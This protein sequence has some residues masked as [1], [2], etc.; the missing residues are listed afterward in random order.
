MARAMKLRPIF[1]WDP[2]HLFRQPPGQASVVERRRHSRVQLHLPVRLRW[3]TPPGPLDGGHGDARGLPRR[4]PGSP[5]RALPGACH[6]L[7]D[8]SL[9]LHPSAGAARDAS[10]ARVEDQ[11]S[12]GS[13]VAID[14]E[15]P[16]RPAARG[17]ASGAERRRQERV[18]VALPIRVRPADSLWPEET[19]TMDITEDG[20]RFWTTRLYSVG[21]DLRIFSPRGSLPSRWIT[22]A[23]LPARI[24]R[25]TSRPG[26]IA[27]E[28]AVA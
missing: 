2:G 15:E 13:L 4:A 24:V 26:S 1:R 23:E 11:P 21:D 5:E 28:V 25:V 9:R 27:Q 19:M 20:V 8:L 18:P 17:G 10:V 6:A 14:L 12:E 7:G 16:P 3:Q 22:T